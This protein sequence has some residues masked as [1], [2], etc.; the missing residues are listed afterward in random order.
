MDTKTAGALEWWA[1]DLAEYLA[2]DKSNDWS[3]E[4]GRLADILDDDDLRSER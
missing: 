3:E 1:R 2:S 4:L